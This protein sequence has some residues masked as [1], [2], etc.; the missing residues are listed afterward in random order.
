MKMK[1]VYDCSVA[2]THSGSPQAFHR[3]P[4]RPVTCE[5]SYSKDGYKWK[6]IFHSNSTL[7]FFSWRTKWDCFLKGSRAATDSSI[8]HRR[9]T[10]T[11]SRMKLRLMSRFWGWCSRMVS[12]LPVTHYYANMWWRA[13]WQRHSKQHRHREITDHL[14]W[15]EQL[16]QSNECK[17]KRQRTTPLRLY[18]SSS[19]IS[20]LPCTTLLHRVVLWLYQVGIRK[21]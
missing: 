9:S 6:I 1:L 4:F 3:L 5:H 10:W 8:T 13:P 19:L 12:V 17:S 20:N 15:R 16:S 21:I 7:G 2:V 14:I 11:A 18:F